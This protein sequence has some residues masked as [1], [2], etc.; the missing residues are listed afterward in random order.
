MA[1][2]T[3]RGG[4]TINDVFVI[5]GKPCVYMRSGKYKKEKL[6]YIPNYCEYRIDKQGYILMK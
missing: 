6:V 1:W 5:N 3:T 2:L 4:R